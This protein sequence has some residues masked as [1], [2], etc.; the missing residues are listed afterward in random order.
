MRWRSLGTTGMRVPELCLGTMTFGYQTDEPTSFAIMDRALEA[1]LIFHDTANVYPLG[2]DLTTVGRT[3]EIMGRWMKERGVRDQLLIATKCFG[4]T[5]EDK[6]SGGLSRLS[7]H[8][9]VEDSLRRLQTDVIDLYQPHHFDPHT[10]IDETLRALEDLVRSGKVRYLGCSNYPAYRLA[11]ALGVS[12]RDRLASFVSVQSRYN[13][14]YREIETELLPLCDDAG[15]GV[16]VYNPIAGGMLAGKYKRGQEPQ[17]DTRFTLGK[18]GNMYQWRYWQDSMIDACEL[19]AAACRQRDL[20][21]A[22]VAVAWVL[23]QPAVTSAIIGASRPDQL[24]ATLL[25]PEVKID[26]DLMKLCDEIFWKLPRR[27][28]IEGYR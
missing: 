12:D 21:P 5:S 22:S 14:L 4:R 16:L 10:P 27:P 18:A 7:I 9:A 26:E 6:N 1:G 20:D 28:V 17:E 3:E 11:Q 15:L 8:R 23:R 13:I 2:G 24:T 19:Y 25:G